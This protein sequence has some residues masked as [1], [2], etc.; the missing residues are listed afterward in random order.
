MYDLKIHDCYLHH[1]AD[2]G[3]YIGSSKY[4]GQTI[5][6]CDEIVVLPHI[7]EGVSIYDNIVENTGWDGIQVSSAPD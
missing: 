5:Y 2:E 3:F 6:Q 4:T 1:I 7:I